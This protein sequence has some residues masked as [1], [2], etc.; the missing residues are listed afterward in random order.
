MS[1]KTINVGEFTSSKGEIREITCRI[2]G[3]IKTPDGETFT[4]YIRKALI[5]E[6]QMGNLYSKMA[7]ITLTGNLDN[8]EFSSDFHFG[9][10]WYLSLTVK[11]SNEKTLKV[12]EKYTFTPSWTGVAACNESAQR[13]MPAVQNLIIKVI[14]NENF[15]N[16]IE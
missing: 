11:S 5:D 14:K 10:Y 6:L 1:G 12:T 3:T 7:P 8:I 16:L 4:N 15:I 13:F 9:G 2:T